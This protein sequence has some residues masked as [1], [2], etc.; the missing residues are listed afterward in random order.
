AHR[1][2]LGEGGGLGGVAE[3]DDHRFKGRA[4]LIERDEHL[5]AIGRERVEIEFH[6]RASHTFSGSSVWAKKAPRRSKRRSHCW[7]RSLSQRSAAVMALGSMRQ[8][9]TRPTF[10]LRTRP[11]SSKTARC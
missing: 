1:R 2:E 10:S 4:L 7:R 8:V 6:H 9:R 5:P 11:L 3:I